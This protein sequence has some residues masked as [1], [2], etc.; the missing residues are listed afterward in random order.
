MRIVNAAGRAGLLVGGRVVDIEDASR[1]RFPSDVQAHYEHWDALRAWAKS[2]EAV[3][4]D[5]AGQTLAEVRLAA[6]VPSPRQVFAIGL[7]YRVHAREGG[8]ELPESPMV[9]TKFPSSICGPCDA[10]ELPTSSVDFEAELVVVIGRRAERVTESD[11]WSHVAGIT[12]GQDLSERDLQTRP[13][14]PQQYSLAKSYPGF[15]PIGPAVV[16]PDEF[17]D[18][19]AIEITGALNGR[20]MQKA[21]TRDLIFDVPALIAYLSSVLPLLPGDLIFT[22]TPSGIGWTRNPRIVLQPGDVLATSAEGIGTM[23]NVMTERRN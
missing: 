1:G 2:D 20:Q 9:F 23:T 17:P 8:V 7:N 5:L 3:G 12:L 15:A 22:G 6:P 18:P 21:S 4:D 11:A 19:D 14:A 13:P 10:I 16:T